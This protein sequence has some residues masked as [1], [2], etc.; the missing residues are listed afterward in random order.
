MKKS[1][2]AAVNE[3]VVLVGGKS[4]VRTSC[5]CTGKW[6]GATNYGF[7]MDGRVTFFVSNGMSLNSGC[8]SG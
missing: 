4:W 3:F 6:S 5:R 7:V 1:E 8:A 2:I